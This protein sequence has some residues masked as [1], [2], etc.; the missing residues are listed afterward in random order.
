MDH[1]HLLATVFL[2]TVTYG[3]GQ[4]E[5]VAPEPGFERLVGCWKQIGELQ[6]DGKMKVSSPEESSIK[7]ITPT[8]FT[9]FVVKN[10]T[11]QATIGFGG[12]CRIEGD[13]YLEIIDSI[14]AGDDSHVGLV[15]LTFRCKFRLENDRWY[16]T[17][18]QVGRQKIPPL[19]QV[20][21]RMKAVDTFAGKALPRSG[22]K[23]AGRNRG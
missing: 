9:W 23:G 5:K 16:H 2:S 1:I 13:D 18:V 8:H 10:R 14:P 6:S 3:G 12:R 7:L 22:R 19:T 17:P 15:P 11:S 4:R 20:W 21:V